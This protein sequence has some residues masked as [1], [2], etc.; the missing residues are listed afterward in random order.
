M[1]FLG[2]MVF[3]SGRRAKSLRINGCNYFGKSTIRSA[4]FKALQAYINKERALV[5][6]V[7]AVNYDKVSVDSSSGNSTEERY[8]KEMDRLKDLQQRYDLLY[9]DLC[10]DEEKIFNLMKMLSP[11]E[12]E[13]I[14]NRFLRGLTRV[15]TACLM[16]YSEDN[17]KHLQNQAIKKMSKN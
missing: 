9:D 17:I 7:G 2:L 1:P 8:I 13:V 4:P 14:L 10:Q 6:G 5:G 11:T 16:N 3:K 12:Y 15:K